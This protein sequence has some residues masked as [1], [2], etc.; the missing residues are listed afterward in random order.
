MSTTMNADKSVARGAALQSA[1]LSPCFKVLPYEIQEAQPFPIKI[2]WDKETASPTQ[3]GVEVEEDTETETVPGPNDIVMFNRG[4]NFPIVRVVTLRRA[5]KF[6]ITAGYDESATQYDLPVDASKDI[7][8]F[9]VTAP[10]GEEKKVRVNVKQDIYG[11]I[12]LSSA[13][14]VEELE[15]EEDPPKEEGENKEDEVEEKKAKEDLS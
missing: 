1:I 5:G 2:A 9:H 14:M 3:Q 13:Q 4:L 15:E 7:A 8:T 11:I 10:L 6:I 12:T